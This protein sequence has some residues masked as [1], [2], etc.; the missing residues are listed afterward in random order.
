[1][2]KR[3]F[4]VPR[5]LRAGLGFGP[6]APAAREAL[7]QN[8]F[9]L[10]NFN[11]SLSA[12]GSA[13]SESL[14]REGSPAPSVNACGLARLVFISGH[15]PW[16]EEGQWRENESDPVAEAVAQPTVVDV[17]CYLK[18][19]LLAFDYPDSGWSF[20]ASLTGRRN[21]CGHFVSAERL[22]STV[23]GLFATNDHFAGEPRTRRELFQAHCSLA[24][25]FE[26]VFHWGGSKRWRAKRRRMRA[27]QVLPIT[28]GRTRIGGQSQCFAADELNR[29]PGFCVPE[30]E[31]YND[32]DSWMNQR[33]AASAKGRRI[34]RRVLIAHEV[35][36]LGWEYAMRY[37]LRPRMP[38]IRTENAEYGGGKGGNREPPGG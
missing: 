1:M 5:I 17:N 15:G 4:Y 6:G 38:E 28:G 25:S 22:S 23:P 31:W 27:R 3:S 32:K 33:T 37:P 2:Y 14:G 10:P 18:G 35:A 20:H 26:K 30:P 34:Q 36:R 24:P 13:N 16:R 8:I 21:I 19:L 12:H 29:P 7:P 11:A 9:S